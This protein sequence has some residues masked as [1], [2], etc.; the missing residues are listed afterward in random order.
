MQTHGHGWAGA[1][2]VVARGPKVQRAE[3]CPKRD[4][5]RAAAAWA[6][7]AQCPW[8]RPQ[9]R[10][11]KK[12]RPTP[13]RVPFLVWGADG[14]FRCKRSIAKAYKTGGAKVPPGG[15]CRRGAQN[16]D[17][18]RGTALLGTARKGC[19]GIGTGM[20]LIRPA[21]ERSA[22]T[23]LFSRFGTGVLSAQWRVCRRPRRA[24]RHRGSR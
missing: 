12:Q 11:Q 4:C 14:V 23:A 5:G 18:S 13:K 6:L 8:G 19:T 2:S 7:Q 20:A 21:A 10:C 15:N 17:Q 9:N 24:V 22:A 1:A 16:A 3:I